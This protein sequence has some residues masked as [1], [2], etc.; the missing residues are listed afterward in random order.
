M[1]APKTAGIFLEIQRPGEE[2]I[3]LPVEVRNFTRDLVTLEV[4]GSWGGM[5]GPSLVGRG[6]VLHLAPGGSGTLNLPGAVTWTRD[7][8]AGE[9]YLTLGLKLAY[10]P[11]TAERLL[12]DHLP[13][14]P[15][16]DIQGLWERW[17]QAR[18]V[19][20]SQA[21]LSSLQHLLA[22]L[23]LLV[24]G[25]TLQLSGGKVLKTFGVAWSLYGSAV[26][27][28]AGLWYWWRRR[29]DAR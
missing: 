22:G 9:D 7:A 12:G 5:I 2:P 8:E 6:C 25:L 1:G 15:H 20:R 26:M 17:D 21:A 10:P 14:M 4:E 24:G 27:A 13:E 18:A 11:R 28:V 23:G 16:R 29:Q 19:S 3:E